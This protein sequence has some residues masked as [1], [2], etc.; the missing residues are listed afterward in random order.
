MKLIYGL[1]ILCVISVASCRKDKFSSAP[2][3]KLKS[4]STEYVPLA[5][6]GQPAPFV[7]FVLEFTDA[8]GDLA[9]MPVAIQKISSS[10]PCPDGSVNPNVLDSTNYKIDSL[11]PA[12]KDL[13]GEIVITLDRASDLNA[14]AC[15]DN[16]TLENATFKFW[17]TD[18]AGNV[19]DTVTAPIIKI[20]K[21]K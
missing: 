12:M 1:L 6:D 11:L 8:E 7:Q 4:V 18:Q 13:K 14:I 21:K 9:T 20:Q 15:N 17:L 2:T 3:L 10:F 16:D 5:L 19:S